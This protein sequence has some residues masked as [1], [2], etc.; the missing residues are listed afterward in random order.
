[1]PSKL[2]FGR[3]SRIGVAL[4]LWSCTALAQVPGLQAGAKAPTISLRDQNGKLQDLGTLSG[5]NGLLLLFFRSAD[6]CPF[7]KGQLVDL[8]GAQQAFAAKGIGVAAI[9][10]DSPEILANFAKRNAACVAERHATLGRSAHAPLWTKK[11][12]L[13]GAPRKRCY[14]NRHSIRNHKPDRY[15]MQAVERCVSGNTVVH[16]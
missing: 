2:S 3:L 16:H 14:G 6:W 13:K 4:L 7:C 8:E 9:S 12:L 1:M 11:P 15:R 10:Y 5:P